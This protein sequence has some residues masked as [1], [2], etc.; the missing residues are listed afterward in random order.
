MNKL[1]AT[2]FSLFLFATVA[3]AQVVVNE[4]MYNSPE[5][6]ADS[7]EFIE[8]YNTTSSSVDMSGW[9]F[10]QGVTYTFPTGTTIGANDYFVL[11][12]DSISF[13][14]VYGFSPDAEWTSGALSN[15]GEDITIIDGAGITIDS[16]DYDDGSPWQT[17]TNILTDGFGSSY[18]LCDAT[19]PNVDET[20][21][22]PSTDTTAFIIN[23]IPLICTPAA[24]NSVSCAA[25]V[26][27]V[28]FAMSGATVNEAAGTIDI[29]L[30]ILNSDANPTSVDVSVLGTSTATGA[31]TDYTFTNPVT[32]TFPASS[33]TNQMV[34]ITITDDIMQEVDET[35]VL[36]LS[37]PTNG[38][39]LGTD[40]VYTLT[41]ED[42]DAPVVVPANLVITEIFYSIPGIDS[43]EFVEIYN[44]DTAAV[45]L[46]GYEISNAIF[47][48]FP[49]ITL[50]MGDY[51][52][53]TNDSIAFQ[54]A[55]GIAAYEWS[56]GNSLNNT[57]ETILLTTASGDFVD[58]VAYMSSSPWPVVGS[59]GEPFSIQLCDVNTDNALA[60]NW[61]YSNNATG[62][63]LDGEEVLA[64][65]AAANTVCVAPTPV[66]YTYYSIDD[67]NDNDVNG[68]ADSLGVTVELRGVVHCGDFASGNSIGFY[69][70][71]Y[72]NV[73]INTYGSAT[74]GFNYTVR[75]GDSLH[76]FGTIDQFNGLTQIVMDS[77]SLVDSFQTTVAPMTLTAAQTEAEENKLIEAV[78]VSL[79]N[80]ADWTGTG[81]GFNVDV[82][83]GTNTWDVRI[84]ADV[85]LYTQP[86]PTGTFNIYGFGNQFDNSS[87]Y[88]QGYQLLAC[89]SSITIVNSV[90]ALNQEAVRIF[91]NPTSTVLNIQ[92]AQI[93]AVVITNTLGQQVINLQNVNNNNLQ[94]NTFDL[95]KG[96]YNIT[97][98]SNG[99]LQTKQFVKQ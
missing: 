1:F 30:S 80:A 82:T 68:A 5:D 69:L 45:D 40:S 56:S 61:G 21:W 12:V 25:P 34:S 65:P 28:E 97:I 26:L 96:L 42:N 91:P 79:V 35:I 49:T 55:F 50:N 94:I 76:V 14:T 33:S 39:I 19:L 46:T 44:N 38:A 4:I 67:I 60:S 10:S 78:N 22:Y 47:Y 74:G 41:I 73:G 84:D 57:G 81:S 27:T 62:V 9:S 71:E 36:E 8:L 86:A 54:N 95:A 92:A 23:G 52:L 83:D 87:P 24:A 53:I 58:S 98:L 85:D 63:F 18:E 70:L 99:K 43:V 29:D 3:Q 2:F 66:T 17:S 11:S 6:N 90:N 72:D 93:D 16:V 51:I 64:T 48:T 59:S 37:N 15:S 89:N 13:V 7:L 20:N 77:I 88:D 32:V 31:G 75:E